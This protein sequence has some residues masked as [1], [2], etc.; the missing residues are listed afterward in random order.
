M[1]HDTCALY[2]IKRL[3]QELADLRWHSILYICN[4]LWIVP[5]KDIDDIIIEKNSLSH[6]RMAHS[7]MSWQ[8]MKD[9]ADTMT[10]ETANRIGSV[11]RW[12]CQ[13]LYDQEKLEKSLDTAPRDALL[14]VCQDLNRMPLTPAYEFQVAKFDN[15]PSLAYYETSGSSIVA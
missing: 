15:C 12:L 13:P 3:Q 14:F 4:D 8:A 7:L 11:H 2:D 6:L 10:Y 9:L 1:Q 5:M